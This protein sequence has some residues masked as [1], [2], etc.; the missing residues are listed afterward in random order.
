MWWEMAEKINNEEK[1]REIQCQDSGEGHACT[2]QRTC[3]WPKGIVGGN[4]RDLRNWRQYDKP[5]QSIETSLSLRHAEILL[6]LTMLPSSF[7]S[8]AFCYTRLNWM[9]YNKSK[10]NALIL[11]AW[12]SLKCLVVVQPLINVSYLNT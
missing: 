9:E 1:R 5:N 6:R 12:I 2:W 10:F 8:V 3:P 4:T 11:H 7:S